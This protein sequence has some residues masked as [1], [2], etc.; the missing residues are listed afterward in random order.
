[1]KKARARKV[2]WWKFGMRTRGQEKA[3]LEGSAVT[4]ALEYLAEQGRGVPL[5]P[6]GV[7][8]KPRKPGQ[9]PK[10]WQDWIAEDLGKDK[11]E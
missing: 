3:L 11:G 10:D 2:T 8:R 7:K 6:L 4:E 5:G 1:M 9:V